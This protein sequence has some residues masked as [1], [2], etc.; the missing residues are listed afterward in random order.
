MN[1]EMLHSTLTKL[2]FN[3]TN[4]YAQIDLEMKSRALAQLQPSGEAPRRRMESDL[5][6]FLRSL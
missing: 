1:L 5:L 6:R 3:T 2:S 4:I